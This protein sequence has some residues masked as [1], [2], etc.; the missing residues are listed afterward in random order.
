MG[1]KDKETG[2][3]ISKSQLEAKQRIA[4]L[5]EEFQILETNSGTE[6]EKLKELTISLKDEEGKVE[7]E[8]EK[9]DEVKED[10]DKE[11]R[12]VLKKIEDCVVV[13]KHFNSS[14]FQQPLSIKKPSNGLKKTSLLLKLSW[15]NKSKLF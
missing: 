12:N 9:L 5:N 2:A 11:F 1:P 15:K 4:K 14:D 6:N 7:I 13:L 3:W 10:V 8:Q